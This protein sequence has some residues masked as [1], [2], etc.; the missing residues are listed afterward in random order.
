MNK[1]VLIVLSVF[2]AAINASA[3]NTQGV[4][5]IGTSA[6][7]S[8]SVCNGGVWMAWKGQGSDTAIYVAPTY[9][10]VK[11]AMTPDQTDGPYGGS[12]TNPVYYLFT[13][14]MKVSSVT[15]VPG[16]AV[17]G[18]TVP[19]RVGAPPIG[20]SKPISVVT[21]STDNSPAL[22]CLGDTLYLFWRNSTDGV[23]YWAQSKAPA[24]GQIPGQTGAAPLMSWTT[25]EPVNFF[26]VQAP[27]LNPN[28]SVTAPVLQVKTGKT[29]AAPSVATSGGNIYLAFKG[30]SD[31]K[32]YYSTF[33]HTGNLGQWSVAKVYATAGAEWDSK[34]AD[35]PLT[36]DSPAIAADG[37]RVYLAWKGAN[38]TQLWWSQIAPIPVSP[39]GTQGAGNPVFN[40][41]AGA[42]GWASQKITD[43]TSNVPP[44]LVADGNGVLWMSWIPLPGTIGGGEELTPPIAFANLLFDKGSNAGGAWSIPAL[45]VGTPTGVGYRP[46]M[47][48]TGNDSTGIM[49]AWKNPGNDAGITLGPLRLPAITYT[50]SIDS[51]TAV[52]TRSGSIASFAVASKDTDFVSLSAAAAG[53]TTVSICSCGNTSGSASG[54]WMLGVLAN[55]ES[56]TPLDVGPNG[57]AGSAGGHVSI[58]VPDD[59]QVIVNYLVNNYGEGSASSEVQLL[60]MA[61]QKLVTAGASAA[62]SLAGTA[63]G[64]AI[65]TAI[66][67]G[68]VPL[69]GSALGALAGW[70]VGDAWGIAF[71]GC[72]GPVAAGVHVISA[73]DLQM[74]TSSSAKPTTNSST[75]TN[76]FWP[77]S[78]TQ[79]DANPAPGSAAITTQ[80][81][82]GSNPIYS[83]QWTI[84]RGRHVNGPGSSD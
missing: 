66:G 51:V 49:M 16:G 34:T 29:S 80:S 72:D 36:S 3:T 38:D 58:T 10:G 40:M 6:S 76:V 75:G 82:C 65:G 79:A 55:G 4:P 77:N 35:V 8:L 25:V 74:L 24:E 62:A 73:Y 5:G 56:N 61:S 11:P 21:P 70:A 19:A 41:P 43:A 52:R 9:T 47:V 23:I 2:S 81:G 7:P 1:Y 31:G 13:P 42:V 18:G 26:G 15:S 68:T 46:A 17:P 20:D 27:V 45:R 44:S 71:P 67:T 32:I 83:V 57:N 54:A 12:A 30:N 59:D 60:Q 69:I 63:L 28:G 78:F 37:N 84:S 48:S 53:G 14:Q 50:F 64:A 33:N 22:T 39:P